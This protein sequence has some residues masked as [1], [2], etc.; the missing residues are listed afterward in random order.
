MAKGRELEAQQEQVLRVA[1]LHR[2]RR[3]V[4]GADGLTI[5]KSGSL[6][7]RHGDWAPS[8]QKAPD[9]STHRPVTAG[10]AEAPVAAPNLPRYE[11]TFLRKWKEEACHDKYRVA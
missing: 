3:G 2:I 8:V 6:L 5:E 10:I 9:S 1:T 4:E 11:A 7:S